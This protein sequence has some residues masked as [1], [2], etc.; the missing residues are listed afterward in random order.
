MHTS[1]HCMTNHEKHPITKNVD[2]LAR[3]PGQRAGL[4]Q[5]AIH[6]KAQ[7]KERRVIEGWETYGGCHQWGYHKMDGS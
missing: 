3:S 5:L 7:M 2:R 4:W 6:L 1:Q